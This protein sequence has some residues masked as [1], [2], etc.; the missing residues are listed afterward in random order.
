[1]LKHASSAQRMYVRGRVIARVKSQQ[2]L[3]DQLEEEFLSYVSS[4]IQ[5]LLLSSRSLR[6]KSKPSRNDATVPSSDKDTS[7]K[8]DKTVP[9]IAVVGI[10]NEN[11]LSP[12]TPELSEPESTSGEEV[13][14]E[15]EVYDPMMD[16]LESEWFEKYADHMVGQP[17]KMK[18]IN[19]SYMVS[20]II[21][22]KL[23]PK[24]ASSEGDDFRRKIC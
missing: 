12:T 17:R 22:K 10:T 6:L 5:R 24:L 16:N 1:M 4:G 3:G 9:A 20:R 2:A 15:D 23:S 7:P 18:R 13:A 11:A 21:A 14:D 8:A 19:N